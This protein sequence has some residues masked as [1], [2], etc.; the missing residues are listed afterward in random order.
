MLTQPYDLLA[1]WGDVAAG[2]IAI[3]PEREKQ[4]AFTTPT[5]SGVTVIVVTKAGV[6]PMAS[7]DDLS[8]LSSVSMSMWTR[9]SWSTH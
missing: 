4:V 6:A 2:D 7:A 8:G 5:F 9:L 1:G 3:T